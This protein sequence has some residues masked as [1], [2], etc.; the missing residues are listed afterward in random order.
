MGPDKGQR[1]DP[2]TV[3]RGV[4]AIAAVKGCTTEEAR[5]TIRTNFRTLFSL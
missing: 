3:P 1:N 5:E 2:S 4:A